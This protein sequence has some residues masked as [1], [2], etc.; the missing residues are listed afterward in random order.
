MSRTPTNKHRHDQDVVGLS[1]RLGL[2]DLD[3]GMKRGHGNISGP[4]SSVDEKGV[5]KSDGESERASKKAKSGDDD[6]KGNLV[7]VGSIQVDPSVHSR[8][9]HDFQ[10]D[11]D[12]MIVL[13][14]RYGGIIQ[15]IPPSA[16]SAGYTIQVKHGDTIRHV[17][18]NFKAR[19]IKECE[20]DRYF[21]DDF[22]QDIGSE[23]MHLF[24]N[25]GIPVVKLC[26]LLTS[27]HHSRGKDIYQ[28]FLPA[29]NW[30]LL[31][32]TA[33]QR[34]F[35]KREIIRKGTQRSGREMEFQVTLDP[36]TGYKLTRSLSLNLDT[37]KS[38]HLVLTAYPYTVVVPFEESNVSCDALYASTASEAKTAVQQAIEENDDE[39]LTNIPDLNA[40]QLQD[41]LY[42]LV[43]LS[44]HS[45]TKDGGF[46]KLS[47]KRDDLMKF[48]IG[49]LCQIRYVYVRGRPFVHES[50]ECI[51][52]IRERFGHFVTTGLGAAL[53]ALVLGLV[54]NGYFHQKESHAVI[55][56]IHLALLESL[57]PYKNKVA[58]KE[59]LSLSERIVGLADS[60]NVF[61]KIDRKKQFPHG[62]YGNFG[63]PIYRMIEA[64][65]PILN[66][67]VLGYFIS[68]RLSFAFNAID[69]DMTEK[70]SGLSSRDWQPEIIPF[71]LLLTGNREVSRAM[72]DIEPKQLNEN[73]W[74]INGVLKALDWMTR[75][76]PRTSGVSIERAYEKAFG[77]SDHGF[78]QAIELLN[79]SLFGSSG[80]EDAEEKKAT[81][82][83][84]EK[85]P[86][87]ISLVIRKANTYSSSS[88]GG[89]VSFRDWTNY[90]YYEPT[91]DGKWVMVK[92]DQFYARKLEAAGFLSCQVPKYYFGHLVGDIVSY[93]D[94]N[95]KI[96]DARVV[97]T[98]LEKDGTLSYHM[99][100][101]ALY[102]ENNTK[103]THHGINF[104]FKLVPG[105]DIL[106]QTEVN[107][108]ALKNARQVLVGNRAVAKSTSLIPIPDTSDSFAFGLSIQDPLSFESFPQANGRNCEV[109]LP[110]SSTTD[111]IKGDDLYELII[112]LPGDLSADP[113][114]DLGEFS[115]DEESFA[116]LRR[117]K[118]A[119]R[120][121]SLVE[122]TTCFHAADERLGAFTNSLSHGFHLAHF[123]FL[124]PYAHE[125]WMFYKKQNGVYDTLLPFY[126]RQSF[127][128]EYQNFYQTY[129]DWRSSEV[130]EQKY[131]KTFASVI[132]KELYA[133]TEKER[134][135]LAAVRDNLVNRVVNHGEHVL[136]HG[137]L[138]PEYI[139]GMTSII[140][141]IG[142]LQKKDLIRNNRVIWF[143]P[144]DRYKAT[145]KNRIRDFVGVKVVELSSVS[146]LTHKFD[147][148]STK[149]VVYIVTRPD[150]TDKESFGAVYDDKLSDEL[151]DALI[152][153][154]VVVENA[155]Q[156]VDVA[157]SMRLASRCMGL[158][159]VSFWTHHGP[160]ETSQMHQLKRLLQAST[161]IPVTPANF[162]VCLRDVATRDT[163]P[164]LKLLSEFNSGL[165]A[166]NRQPAVDPHKSRVSANI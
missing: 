133:T 12:K 31:P 86:G 10:K 118:E 8:I 3:S 98:S 13:Y 103:G 107:D 60:G 54:D 25:E 66:I 137:V 28:Y 95:K 56:A 104:P 159:S 15:M 4:S 84:K 7:E 83:K 82:F 149:P 36:S 80:S 9:Y 144:D 150:D 35:S 78:L 71:E 34:S 145:M 140:G 81:Q 68:K 16:S 134:A 29:S 131:K 115:G 148:D 110:G 165:S 127:E 120:V 42:N 27:S 89:R 161:I 100:P 61:E 77:R 64:A 158:A 106:G 152:D 121:L 37:S 24:V 47:V 143:V 151:Y 2:F 22:F 125:Q 40:E 160:I 32:E 119:R 154:C 74:T 109:G 55:R 49:K 76:N 130:P 14:H 141:A 138:F 122:S 132:T 166:N 97:T 1:Q 85:L 26:D 108:A 67:G 94:A 99:I 44:P 92:P 96:L 117:L 135:Y 17:F 147:E 142:E 102:N 58:L 156:S 30:F 52:V 139:D 50:T 79:K 75:F 57:S 124:D 146:L 101:Y 65:K 5:P 162:G 105:S 126:V 90:T 59:V 163:L 72:Y 157:K 33:R 114:N 6:I 62:E 23:D 88:N 21:T 164:S 46:N 20:V 113:V 63:L 43:R 129:L 91:K 51:G 123:E 18:A 19:L 87:Q 41:A 39:L 128:R 69:V 48:L 70:P 136:A 53:Y 116:L 111:V 93:N 153:G 73:G 38:D 45:V 155:I 112:C 11:N